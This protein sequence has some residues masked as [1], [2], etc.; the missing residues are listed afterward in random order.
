MRGKAIVIFI[1]A[2]LI[3]SFLVSAQGLDEPIKAL[4]DLISSIYNKGIE[5][6]AKYIIGGEASQDSKIFFSLILVFVMLLSLIWI[7]TDRVPLLNEN[8][9]LQFIVSFTI[10]TLSVRFMASNLAWFETVLLPNQALG[11]T[12]VTMLP[13]V[14]Y[15]FFVQDI[16]EGKPTLRKIMWVFAAVFFFTIYLVRYPDLSKYGGS[17]NPAWVYLIGTG[18]CVLLLAFDGTI[19]RTLRK[20]KEQNIIAKKRHES[21]IALREKLTDLDKKLREEIITVEEYEKRRK[22][23]EKI[24]NRL[25]RRT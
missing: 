1:F 5:P 7:I 8:G 15:F 20:I 18:I 17:F 2:L 14:I 21:L 6:L 13:L 23:I 10:A 4:G 24:I 16:G 11:V 19:R 9:W 3:F 22:E 12:L 25:S